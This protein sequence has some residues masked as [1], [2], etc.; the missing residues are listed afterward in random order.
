VLQPDRL[1]TSPYV[2]LPLS[3]IASIRLSSAQ[4]INKTII[5]I[6]PPTIVRQTTVDTSLT[7]L[8][9]LSTSSVRP[10]APCSPTS[11]SFLYPLLSA[12]VSS[13]SPPSR[14]RLSI[15]LNSCDDDFRLLRLLPVCQTIVHT[16]LSR[17]SRKSSRC[18]LLLYLFMYDYH[19]NGTG[20][21]Y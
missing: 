13:I 16:T 6:S 8:T 15:V 14:L 10:A 11:A 17:M 9:P 1:S 5:S 18:C 21:F 4:S 3:T 12:D 2:P 20:L 7:L 19:L